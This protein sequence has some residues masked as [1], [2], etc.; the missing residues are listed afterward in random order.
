MSQG[1]FF[2]ALAHGLRAHKKPARRFRVAGLVKAPDLR[3]H[4][5][6]V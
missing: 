5:R 4:A 3:S 2:A 1:G 6:P